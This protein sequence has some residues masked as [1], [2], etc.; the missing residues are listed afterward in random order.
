MIEGVPAPRAAR[1]S[2]VTASGSSNVRAN[3]T[4]T[5]RWRGHSGRLKTWIATQNNPGKLFEIGL[6]AQTKML[7]RP[8]PS[9][10]VLPW[11]PLFIDVPFPSVGV[12]Q[13][14]AGVILTLTAVNSFLTAGVLVGVPLMLPLNISVLMIG[15]A[16]SWRLQG[17]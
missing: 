16:F 10:S 14:L 11:R 17:S 2:A 8:E 15:T 5:G 6:K 3:A 7:Q 1:S 12:Q 9:L 4:R 13:F